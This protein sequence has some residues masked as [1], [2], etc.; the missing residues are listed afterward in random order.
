MNAI[1]VI[2]REYNEHVKKKSFVIGTILVPVFML[3]FLFVPLLLAFFQPD[4][5]LSVAV[6]D[7]T[8]QIG[9]AFA[10]S[11]DDTTKSGEPIA[12]GP[13]SIA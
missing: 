7:H 5:Q 11:F 6:V 8:G 12:T 9:E 2:R 4:E 3:A 10:T 1:H 13:Q